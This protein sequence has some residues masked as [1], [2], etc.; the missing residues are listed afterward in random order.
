MPEDKF[1]RKSLPSKEKLCSHK[2]DTMMKKKKK[3]KKKGDHIPFSQK[4]T[5]TESKNKE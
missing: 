1:Q 5:K 2:E 4:R 3:K